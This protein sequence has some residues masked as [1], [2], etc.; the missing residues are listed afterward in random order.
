MRVAILGNSG[1]G[2]STLAQWLAARA[3]APL[4]DLDTVAWEPERIAVARSPEAASSDVA[5]FCSANANWVVEGCYGSLVEA[6]LRFS[7][8]LLF[9]NPGERQCLANCRARPWEP[10]KYASKQAQDERLAML[11]D[12]VSAYYT[13]A[14]DMSLA[15]H[16]AC[17]ARY[18]GRKIEFTA[19]PTLDPPAEG[20]LDLLG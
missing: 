4:L 14:G 13:R 12:W 1:S 11:L 16:C 5:A 18:A 9:L 6:A 19:Q 20:I 3:H 2:K 10:H 8:A 7:P 17:F 15:G